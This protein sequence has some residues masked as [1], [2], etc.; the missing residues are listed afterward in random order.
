MLALRL[1]DTPGFTG[2][3]ELPSVRATGVEA[4]PVLEATGRVAL[5]LAL[6]GAAVGRGGRG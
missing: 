4:E 2:F 5:A 1:S 6:V 3:S